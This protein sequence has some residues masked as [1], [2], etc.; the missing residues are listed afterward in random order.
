[1]NKVQ[2]ANAFCE[3]RK[4]L[5]ALK[6]SKKYKKKAKELNNSD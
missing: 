3:R 2:Q 6:K 5:K 4:Q 1:M